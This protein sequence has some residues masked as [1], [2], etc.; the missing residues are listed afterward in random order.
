[1]NTLAMIVAAAALATSAPSQARDIT[2]QDARKA[3][4]KSI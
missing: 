2:E 4:Q 1:M 3:S